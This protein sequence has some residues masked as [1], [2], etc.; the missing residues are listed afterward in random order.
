[1]GVAWY[2]GTIQ[3]CVC[4]FVGGAV[5]FLTAQATGFF[6]GYAVAQVVA[7]GLLLALILAESWWAH[8]PGSGNELLDFAMDVLMSAAIAGFGM[9]VTA[10]IL[11]WLPGV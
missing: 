2:V 6:W 5:W 8:M 1:M 7:T 3:Y 11:W 10:A 4:L 9:L